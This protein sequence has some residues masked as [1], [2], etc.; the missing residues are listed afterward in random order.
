MNEHLWVSPDTQGF[1]ACVNR[2][3][4]GQGLRMAYF[5]GFNNY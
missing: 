4:S 1:D 5:W 3:E 2:P